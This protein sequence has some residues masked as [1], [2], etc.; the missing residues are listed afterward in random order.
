M[1]ITM[2][3]VT[4]EPYGE[5]EPLCWSPIKKNISDDEDEAG[6]TPTVEHAYRNITSSMQADPLEISSPKLALDLLSTAV[7]LQNMPLVKQ[8]IEI[9]DKQLDPSILISVI[10]RLSDC[11]S[12]SRDNFEPS[13]PPIIESQNRGNIDWVQ[14]LI[15]NLRHNCLLEIDRYADAILK[16]L[17][18]STLSY[19]DV[20]QI[21]T[22]DSLQV[23]SETVVYSAIMKWAHAECYRR[24]LQPHLPNLKAVLRDLVHAPRYGLMTKKEFTSRKIDGEKGPT[25][26]GILDEKEWRRILFYIREKSKNRPVEELPFRW[27]TPR[28]IGSEKPKLLSS[29]SA[30]RASDCPTKDLNCRNENRCDKVFLNILTCWTAIFD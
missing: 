2:V 26:S 17:F 25:K 18:F 13:A 19:N 12:R 9:I 6:K 7:R 24:T 3:V 30:R 21:T 4:N 28:S 8:C 22:R 27:S 10:S 1:K 20:L 11:S 15:N 16:D 23:S 29:K 14:D 5:T